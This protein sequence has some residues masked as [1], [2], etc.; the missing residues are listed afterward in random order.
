[1]VFTKDHVPRNYYK[2]DILFLDKDESHIYAVGSCGK[3]C[4]DGADG[5][6][7]GPFHM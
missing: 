7:R 4:V 5:V 2:D 3:H 6:Q 1:M